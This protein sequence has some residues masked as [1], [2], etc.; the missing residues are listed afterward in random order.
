MRQTVN[1]I[2]PLS[3]SKA[4]KSFLHDRFTV[5]LTDVSAAIYGKAPEE[6]SRAEF[7]LMT[8]ALK[9]A[10]WRPD[11]GTPDTGAVRKPP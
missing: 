10:G 7:G 4:V 2:N 3:V 1:S 5:S 6:L 9:G 11:I 8:Y